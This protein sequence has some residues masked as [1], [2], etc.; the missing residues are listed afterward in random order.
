MDCFPIIKQDYTRFFVVTQ[1]V[2]MIVLAP[3]LIIYMGFGVA[4]E[5]LTGCPDVLFPNRSQLLRRPR[6]GG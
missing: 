1:T 3:I 6:P 5:N 2:P 4:P